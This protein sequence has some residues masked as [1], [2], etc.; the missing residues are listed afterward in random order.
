[1]L[2]EAQAN[3]MLPLLASAWEGAGILGALEPETRQRFVQAALL[4]K[5]KAAL[6]WEEL[7]GLLGLLAGCGLTPVLLKGAH[8]AP[9]Y[10][11]DVHLRPMSDIDLCFWDLGEARRAFDVL[12]QAGYGAEEHGL[13]GDP[14]AYDQ[15]LAVLTHPKSRA[16]VEVHG[17][18]IYAPR[19]RRWE[20]ASVLLQEREAASVLGRDVW[21]LRPEAN[22]VYLL[23]HLLVH[24]GSLPPTLIHLWDIARIQEKEADRFDW[25]RLVRLAASSGLERP[26]ARGLGMVQEVLGVPIPEEVFRALGAGAGG[27]DAGELVEAFREDVQTRQ[28]LGRVAHAPGVFGPVVMAFHMAFPPGTFLRER[29]P[30]KQHWPRPLLYPYRWGLQL[31]RVAKLVLRVPS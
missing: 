23:A 31:W 2:E 26:T 10:Y 8:L 6:L 12:R 22:V 20:R 16:Q 5:A 3:G 7:A 18:L 27:Q 13:E 28:V 17:S 15:H 19:D 24:H 9:V 25:D 29:Y 21:V 1:M 4:Q 11:G 30:D 14:W